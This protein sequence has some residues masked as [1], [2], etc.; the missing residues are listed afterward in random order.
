MK[1][2]IIVDGNGSPVAEPFDSRA[3][4]LRT[5]ARDYP[6]SYIK[7]TLAHSLLSPEEWLDKWHEGWH[8]LKPVAYPG[9]MRQYAEYVSAHAWR[10]ALTQAVDEMKQHFFE[11]EGLHTKEMLFEKVLSIEKQEQ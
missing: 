2:Y 11:V 4:A 10:E 5:L 3:D 6:A 8:G 1:K 7:E 9:L